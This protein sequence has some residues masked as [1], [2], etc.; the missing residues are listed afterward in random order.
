M[1]MHTLIYVCSITLYKY[2]R[3][4]Y[5]IMQTHFKTIRPSLFGWFHIVKRYVKVFVWLISI[6]TFLL[7]NYENWLAKHGQLTRFLFLTFSNHKSKFIMLDHPLLELWLVT[8]IQLVHHIKYAYHFWN[9]DHFV[10]GI[11][12]ILNSVLLFDLHWF[13]LSNLFRFNLFSIKSVINYQLTLQLK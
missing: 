3:T 9:S 1:W 4:T 10:T 6:S 12:S 2:K 8:F 13:N 11:Y 7:I 5:I